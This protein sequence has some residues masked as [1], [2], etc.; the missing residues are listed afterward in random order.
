MP[1]NR[2]R[3]HKVRSLRDYD[4]VDHV[5]VHEGFSISVCG[6]EVREEELFVWEDYDCSFIGST[7]RSFIYSFKFERMDRMEKEKGRK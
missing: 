6:W 1:I 2:S 3:N 5:S 7:V 4:K